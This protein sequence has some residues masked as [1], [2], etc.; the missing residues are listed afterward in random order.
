MVSLSSGRRR[1]RQQ[2]VSLPSSLL[3]LFFEYCDGKTGPQI[4]QTAN[5]KI[6]PMV[7]RIISLCHSVLIWETEQKRTTRGETENALFRNGGHN[8]YKVG[9]LFFNLS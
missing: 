3:L 4:N 6:E 2:I 8:H 1:S 9:R 7:I 5:M